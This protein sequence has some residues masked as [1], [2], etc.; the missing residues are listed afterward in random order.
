MNTFASRRIIILK[1]ITLHNTA[2]QLVMQDVWYFDRILKTL[3]DFTA[4]AGLIWCNK[5]SLPS[6]LNISTKSGQW[7]VIHMCRE[8]IHM[9][10]FWYRAFLRFYDYPMVFRNV[11][12][13]WYFCF[14]FYHL[15][16]LITS[17][18]CENQNPRHT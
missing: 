2:S 9:C 12:T 1:I 8:V 16:Y 15:H 14:P 13:K 17:F 10:I 7:E 5:T 11:L 18:S 3:H 4:K 6:P